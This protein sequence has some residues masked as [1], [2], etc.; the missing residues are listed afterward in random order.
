MTARE[1]NLKLKEIKSLLFGFAMKLT[2]NHDK[3]ND[4]MQETIY[5]GFKNKKSFTTNTNFKAWMTTIMRNAFIN[6][7][8]KNKTRW[9][10]ETPLEDVRYLAADKPAPDNVESVLMLNELK[11]M[12]Q[13]LPQEQMDFFLSFYKGF[14]YKEIAAEHQVPIG[15]VKS[16]IYFARQKLQSMARAKYGSLL[17][18]HRA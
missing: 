9:K 7:Y 18:S 10:V 8:R 16:R 4:L 15:T 2:K 5:K 17:G 11:K 6:Q 13:Q 12:I 3:A 1:F 14:S